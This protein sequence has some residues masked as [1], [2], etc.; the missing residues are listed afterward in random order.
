M[1]RNYIKLAFRHLL[2]KKTF[3]FIN[4]FGLTIGLTSC[5]LIGLFIS[6]ELGFDAFNVKAARIARVTSEYSSSGTVNPAAVS[7]TRVGPRFHSIFP[8]IEAFTRT[9]IGRTI[10]SNEVTHFEENNFLYA[11]SAFFDIFTFPILKGD[12][13]P[14][15]SKDNLVITESTA[16][17]Y[18]GGQDPI[19]K[20]LRIRDEKIYRVAAVIADPPGASQLQFDFVA[21]FDNLDKPDEW[22]TANW[23]TYLLLRDPK[24]FVP[25][26]QQINAYMQSPAIRNETGEKGNDYL[27]YHLE[28][29]TRV[30]LY[31]KL[32]GFT[33]NG[34]ITTVYVL[35]IIAILILAIACFNYTNLAIAQSA[36]RMGEIGVRKVLGAAK[37]Q[38]FTQFT[39]ESL[40]ITV[41]AVILA[42]AISIQLLPAFNGV[43]GKHLSWTSLVQIRPLG[44][45]LGATIFIGFLAG[46]YP[47]L[48]LSNTRLISIL[49]SGFRVTGGHRGFRSSLVVLQFAISLF[50]IITT[51]VI[52]QQMSYIRHKDLGFD[53]DHIVVL[54]ID[55]RIH[56]RYHSVK[57]AISRLPGVI[58]ISGSYNL[59]VSVGWEDGIT[60]NNGKGEVSVSVHAIPTDLDFIRTM[61]MHLVAGKDFTAFDLPA[62]TGKDSTK[63]LYRFILNETAARKIG[64]TPED[65]IGKQ[66]SKGQSGIVVGVVRDFNFTSM[67]EAIGP[68]I[69][70]PDTEYVRYLLVRINGSH[71]PAQ[72]DR[73]QSAWKSIIPDRPFSYHFLDDD[74]DRLYASEQRTGQLF[75]LFSGLAIFLALLGLF[76]LAAIS[77]V[78]RTK[79]IGIRKV[80]GAGSMNI[81]LLLARNFLALIIVSFGIATPV[82]WIVSANWLDNFSYRILLPVWTFP[83]A[84]LAVLLVAFATVSF[85]AWRA[86][87]MNPAISLKTE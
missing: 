35:M 78:Q 73:M 18:F 25:L 67:R 84:G 65:A 57:M 47:A 39:G 43:T 28:P 1:F 8:A 51:M 9:Y 60:A 59:P 32:E 54:P 80:L 33:P 85:H 87:R 71:L 81:A 34:S 31:S 46:A 79:E 72:L 6:D 23:I 13:D 36:G 24:G 52:L 77:T 19:G 5:I 49:R 83:L 45:I 61:N 14:L 76:G 37:S 3:S 11:D 42:V 44:V 27:I 64:W 82:A 41:L 55:Y 53:R 21:R 66:V 86:S 70:F 29:L 74:Y 30:H 12:P 48:V 38:L 17:K 22:W 10:V 2:K 50:L 15:K 7:G 68:L 58:D 56:D 26:E 40:L 20:T 75:T 62:I 4:I 69:I 63:P 16:K